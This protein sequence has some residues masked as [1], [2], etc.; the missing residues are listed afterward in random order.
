MGTWSQMVLSLNLLKVSRDLKLRLGFQITCSL[1][2]TICFL[3]HFAT[4]EEEYEKELINFLAK[5]P[6][7]ETD[8]EAFERS[9]AEMQ[10]KQEDDRLHI[11][12]EYIGNYS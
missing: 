7:F 8:D 2:L 3:R 12:D 9:M 5:N 4:K 11:D 6:C 10:E 1:M